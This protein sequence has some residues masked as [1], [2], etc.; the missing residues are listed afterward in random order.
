MEVLSKKIVSK[1]SKVIT[2]IQ[3]GDGNFLRGFAEDYIKQTNL[4]KNIN[5]GVAVIAPLR[6][7]S[8]W[9]KNKQDY[10][11]RI[12]RKG[13]DKGLLHQSDDLIDVIE[14]SINPY[15]QYTEFI[16]LSHI[17]TLKYVISNSTE[18]G[19]EYLP[20]NLLSDNCPKSY[21]GKLTVFLYSRFKHFRHKENKGLLILPCELIEKNGEKLKG[22]CIRLAID[23]HLE[24]DFIQWLERENIFANT[25]VDRIVVGYPD[26]IINE[27]QDNWGYIDENCVLT[28]PF[29]NWIIELKK[30]EWQHIPFK[31]KKLNLVLTENLNQHRIMKVRVLNGA[32]TVLVPIGLL[33]NYTYVNESIKDTMIYQLVS[34]TL[35]EE[36]LKTIPLEKLLVEEFS[37][38]VIDRFNN[39]FIYHKLKDISLNSTSKIKT[40][41]LPA[42]EDNIRLGYFPKFLLFALSVWIHYYQNSEI[43]DQRE[44]LAKWNS[45]K[46]IDAYE[47]KIESVLDWDGFISDEI[48]LNKQVKSFLVYYLE[49][50]DQKGLNLAL[51]EVLKS[52]EIS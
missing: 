31:S 45:L 23:N 27:L 48:K 6:E 20:E 3:F 43:I 38:S 1:E 39:P 15:E 13:Y 25:L 11:Y 10:L 46:K 24:S 9:K 44:Y 14:E 4:E 52:D 7:N 28:E 36:V 12:V 47:L 40:R 50:I 34:R 42:I 22:I 41:I 33:L 19:I 26:R 16:K 5:D 32:H 35:K 8:Y 17:E 37:D 49:L 30:E 21:P 2:Y 29:C 51:E 18:A